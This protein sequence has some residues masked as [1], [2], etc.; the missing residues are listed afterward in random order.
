MRKFG[1]VLFL[2]STIF[3]CVANPVYAKSDVSC[4]D[5]NHLVE[6]SIKDRDDLLDELDS[7]VSNTYEQ[8]DDGELYSD[9]E[10]ITALPFPETVGHEHDEVYYEMAKNFCGEEIANE[11]WLVR[12]HFPKW[13]GKS[14]SASEGQI[15]LAKNEDNKWFVWFRYH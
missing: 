9:W 4:P 6:T 8:G 7:I 11:S 1:V 10:L 2:I 12:L 3:F 5:I 15:F 13:E 14:T